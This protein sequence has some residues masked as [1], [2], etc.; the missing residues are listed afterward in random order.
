MSRIPTALFS[1]DR[2]G[3]FIIPP[4]NT[5]PYWY[6][7][8]NG[9]YLTRDFS[10][11]NGTKINNGSNHGQFYNISHQQILNRSYQHFKEKYETN[12]VPHK[13]KCD[14]YG[15]IKQKRYSEMQMMWNEGLFRYKY[16]HILGLYIN[17]ANK[18]CVEEAIQFQFLIHKKLPLYYYHQGCIEKYNAEKLI[19]HHKINVRE[20][21]KSADLSKQFVSKSNDYFPQTHYYKLMCNSPHSRINLHKKYN[22]ESGETT[23]RKRAKKSNFRFV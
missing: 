3:V 21:R 10:F 22:F 18:I 15:I 20:I 2:V 7:G 19:K 17:P 23:K 12:C 4:N 1:S 5:I 13:D 14:L 11:M 16:K 9:E 6:D 8:S